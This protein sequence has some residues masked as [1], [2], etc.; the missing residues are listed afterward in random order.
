MSATKKRKDWRPFEEAREYVRSLRLKSQAEWM[1]YSKS[2]KC[3]SDIPTVPQKVYQ[4][5]W[6]SLPDWL[7]YKRSSHPVGGW[8]PFE[9]AREYVRGLGLKGMSEWQ[10]WTK[11]DQRPEDIPAS[12][13]AFYRGEWRGYGDWLG[14][15]NQWTRVALLAL[16]E[17]LRAA[18]IS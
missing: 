18:S 8:R 3:P 5:E 15:A 16:L 17:D 14:T 10:A 9:K 13:R 12:P 7:G 6:R 11:T 2:G 1:K 4:D